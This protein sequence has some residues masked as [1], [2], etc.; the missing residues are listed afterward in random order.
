MFNT[1]FWI[2]AIWFVINVIWMWFKL[3]DQ[4][5]KRPSPGLMFVPLLSVSVSTTWRG[6]LAAEL[7]AG[8]LR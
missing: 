5:Y 7:M 3:D 6:Q 1:V 2:L 8:L 4:T